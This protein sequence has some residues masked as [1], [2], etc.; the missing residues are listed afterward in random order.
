MPRKPAKAK[1]PRAGKRLV[2]LTHHDWVK[3][4]VCS[5]CG[6]PFTEKD[7]Y[8]GCAGRP[9]RE[10]KV[11]PATYALERSVCAAAEKWYQADGY[12]VKSSVNLV[13]AVNALRAHKKASRK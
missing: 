2:T 1:G 13:I 11:D 12:D 8:R 9:K 4:P 7:Q 3:V 10:K 6:I 5:A